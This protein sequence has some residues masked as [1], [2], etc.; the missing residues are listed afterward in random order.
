[1]ARRPRAAPGGFPYHVLNHAAGKNLRIL[2]RE[3]DFI[4]FEKLLIEAHQRFPIRILAYCLMG[5]HWHFVVWPEADG[6]VTNFFRW[7]THTHVMRWRTAHDT[8][9]YGP[10][11]RGRFKSFPIQRDEHLLTVCRYVE[12]N[13]LTAGLVR[14]AQDWRWSSLHAREQGSEELRGVL[15]PW[16]VE[17]PADWAARVNQPLTIKEK[18][19]MELSMRR[20][21]PFGDERW[22]A[23][24]A[25][26]L[27]LE[28]TIRGEGRPAGAKGRG[29]S[30]GAKGKR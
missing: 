23:Q 16:P 29:K 24:T 20:G 10:L 12:R 1:M 21:R 25:G 26:R 27:D 15:S 8:V 22:T 11:Y 6:E 3:K 13:A 18:E 28:H 17:R 19:A 2:S 5:T 14:R 9:G 7:L 4:A 30:D